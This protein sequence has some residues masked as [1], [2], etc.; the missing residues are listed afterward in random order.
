MMSFCVKHGKYVTDIYNRMMFADVDES[1]D[2]VGSELDLW[3]SLALD[4]LDLNTNGGSTNK[5]KPRIY[6]T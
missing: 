2:A 3:C 5:A 4:T 1:F 6:R